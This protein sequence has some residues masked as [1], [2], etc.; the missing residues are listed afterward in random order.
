M[1]G[2]VFLSVPSSSHVRRHRRY[3]GCRD[4]LQDGQTDR[5]TR[6]LAPCL[7]DG[8]VTLGARLLL[9]LFTD[10]MVICQL[11]ILACVHVQAL[12]E[13]TYTWRPVRCYHVIIIMS[14][15]C[16]KIGIFTL[17]TRA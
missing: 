7:A 3:L 13:S 12:P 16:V 5:Q 4:R 14:F 1:V 6:R 17:N 2:D 15:V 9:K 11:S 10:S 8:R